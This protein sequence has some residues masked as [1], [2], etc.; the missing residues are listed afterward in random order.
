[1]KMSRRSEW[2]L[3]LLISMKLWFNRSGP[4]VTT[5]IS[6]LRILLNLSS[7]RMLCLINHRTVIQSPMKNPWFSNL[8]SCK[9]SKKPSILKIPAWEPKTK[10]DGSSYQIAQLQWVPQMSDSI[11]NGQELVQTMPLLPPAKTS[12]TSKRTQIQQQ[13]QTWSMTQWSTKTVQPQKFLILNIK[14]PSISKALWLQH[15]MLVQDIQLL[16][17]LLL[18]RNEEMDKLKHGF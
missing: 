9:T 6:K 8:P 18:L 12:I 13:N 3:I 2:I 11:C 4:K 7:R 1:M 17:L 5:Q 16:L 10:E 14:L 15:Q